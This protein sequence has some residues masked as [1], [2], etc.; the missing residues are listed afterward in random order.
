[1]VFCFL[2]RVWDVFLLELPAALEAAV[3]AVLTLVWLGTVTLMLGPCDFWVL[4]V[5][6]ALCSVSTLVGLGVVF[7]LLFD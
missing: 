1:M 4:E 7:S 6:A 2:L 3:E 5:P